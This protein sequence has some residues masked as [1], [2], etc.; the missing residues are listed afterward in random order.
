MTRN[1][2]LKIRGAITDS[3]ALGQIARAMESD[4]YLNSPSNEA[5]AAAFL[6]LSDRIGPIKGNSWLHRLLFA[7]KTIP[8]RPV[9]TE[10][11]QGAFM[12]SCPACES[13]LCLNIRDEV[14]ACPWCGQKIRWR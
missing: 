3:E 4:C 6:A 8:R 1:E 13:L 5:Y 9:Y 12:Y 10:H 2:A 7:V 11:P 14:P